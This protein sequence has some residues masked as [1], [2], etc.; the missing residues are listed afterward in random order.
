MQTVRC[1][2]GKIVCQ[3]EN[4][5]GPVQSAETP[6]DPR[7]PSVVIMCRHCKSF[8][9]LEVEAVSAIRGGAATQA[10]MALR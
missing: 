5:P 8:V 6:R 7:G 4:L 2:C 1:R 3:I 10:N 9:T